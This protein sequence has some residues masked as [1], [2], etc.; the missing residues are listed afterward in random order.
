[1]CLG[2]VAKASL[3]RVDELV[4]ES[5]E[6]R[7]GRGALVWGGVSGASRRR[8]PRARNP[9]TERPKKNWNGT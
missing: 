4:G 3:A 6:H 9:Q 1:M 8:Y 2:P 5:R 7:E